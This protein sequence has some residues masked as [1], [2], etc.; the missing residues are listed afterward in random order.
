[1]R[2]C[3]SNSTTTRTSVR[4]RI[5]RSSSVLPGQS[6][7]TAFRCMPGTT[8]GAVRIVALHLSAVTV[9]TMSDPWAAAAAEAQRTEIAHQ[10]LG[11]R[12]V[13]VEQAHFADAEHV[14]EGDHLEFALRAIADERH[15][16]A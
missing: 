9:V 5:A 1:M 3:G 12:R 15:D 13:D 6:P 2:D 14:V 16:A 4:S 8:I 11:G 7:P 10:L